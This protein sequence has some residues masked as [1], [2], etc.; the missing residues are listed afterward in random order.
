MT[1]QETVVA[2]C[3]CGSTRPPE[4]YLDPESEESFA[5]KQRRRRSKAELAKLKASLY[6]ILQ[7]QNPA[8][9]RQVFYQAVAR[10]MIEK[11][12]AEYKTVVR[13]LAQ[14]RLAGELPFEWIVDFTRWMRKPSTYESV[15]DA[16][17]S[18][19]EAYRRDLWS[20]QPVH[21][22][23]WLEK[24]ALAGVVY[25]ETSVYDVPLMV[26]RGFSSLTFLHSTAE[27]IRELGKPVYIYLLGDYDPSGI[28]ATQNVEKRLREFAPDAE[29][30]FERLAVTR[31][32][33]RLWNLPTRPT[34][35]T[36]SRAKNFDSES[37]ELDA[38]P[39][40][41]LRALVREAIE[42][43]IDN[44]AL[45]KARAVES[46]ERKMLEALASEYY[47]A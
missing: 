36:D 26:Q 24:D 27:D 22:E 28:A 13:L 16:L 21:V 31:E 33:I 11:T 35:K 41:R 37:V 29:L 2:A 25:E 39:P 43:H 46:S 38:I 15:A 8:T 10:G 14:M 3:V 44:A 32:Q 4:R 45:E 5:T 34:K 47:G 1:A 17:D 20:E 18:L 42:R 23:I 40:E 19:A 30:N 7:A 6:S 9:V 12:E